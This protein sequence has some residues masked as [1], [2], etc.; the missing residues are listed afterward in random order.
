MESVLIVAN[1]TVKEI[2]NPKNL[3]KS[4]NIKSTSCSF[5]AEWET[6]RQ[7]PNRS[8]R[9][10]YSFVTSS[11]PN[12]KKVVS[13][14]C[15]VVFSAEFQTKTIVLSEAPL[16]GITCFADFFKWF[17]LFMA[18]DIKLLKATFRLTIGRKRVAFMKASS[19]ID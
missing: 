7:R 8:T 15:E 13:G 3:E 11:D 5:F 4:A 12:G 6:N 14:G 10:Q 17:L 16:I 2:R 1:N 19:C 18:G 9:T